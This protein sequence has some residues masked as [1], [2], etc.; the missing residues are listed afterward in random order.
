MVKKE[1][2]LEKKGRKKGVIEPDSRERIFQA[3]LRLFSRKGYAGTGMRELATEAGV[4]LAMINYF[5]GSKIGL[6]KEILDD[7][8]ENYIAIARKTLIGKEAVEI[9]LR[10][11]IET[12]IAYFDANQEKLLITIAELPRDEPEITE[13]KAKWAARMVEIVQENVCRE[14][15]VLHGCR[16]PVAFVGPPLVGLMSFYF[17]FRPVMEKAQPPGFDKEFMK[18][19][20]RVVADIFI[21]G[22]NGLIQNVSKEEG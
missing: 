14:L 9:R 19:Y 5:Y 7:Y 20:P 10:N 2:F 15:E 12:A 21:N 8:F 11:F 4:N 22:L 1:I 16:L 6:L 18:R 17:L 3:A 13:Y